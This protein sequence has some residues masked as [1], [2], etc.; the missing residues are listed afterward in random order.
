MYRA[1][2]FSGGRVTRRDAPGL[3][4]TVTEIA[5]SF[6][7][8]SEEKTAGTTGEAHVLLLSHAG[9]TPHVRTNPTII[10]RAAHEK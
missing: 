8:S 7:G 9:M 2:R 10:G 4:Y 6:G 5:K 1:G 3:A